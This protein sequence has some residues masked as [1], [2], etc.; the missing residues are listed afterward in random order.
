MM[1]FRV[2]PEQL[3]RFRAVAAANHRTVSQ[4]LRLLMEQRIAEADDELEQAA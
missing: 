1:N 3:E 4:E 2:D